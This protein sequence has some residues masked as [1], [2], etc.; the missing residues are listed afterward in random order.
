MGAIV[1]GVVAKALGMKWFLQ[2]KLKGV[3]H[4]GK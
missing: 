4:R 1:M 3:R 2:R